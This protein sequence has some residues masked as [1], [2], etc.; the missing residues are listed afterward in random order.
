[1]QYLNL[2]DFIT[3][4]H[5]H[6][7]TGCVWQKNSTIFRVFYCGKSKQLSND[8]P[9]A[10]NIIFLCVRRSL[11]GI[12]PWSGV[13]V[14]VL[15]V[16]SGKN[17]LGHFRHYL[18]GPFSVNTSHLPCLSVVRFHRCSSG[19]GIYLVFTGLAQVENWLVQTYDNIS[20]YG[21]PIWMKQNLIC[22]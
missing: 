7:Y 21:C 15:W 5:N 10:K 9:V 8:T 6:M 14:M 4:V 19:R 12:I 18:A 2:F 1:M 20:T 16:M 3:K 13:K 11:N 17:K 22:S